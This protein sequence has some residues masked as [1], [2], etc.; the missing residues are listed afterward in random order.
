MSSEPSALRKLGAALLNAT[1]MLAA[2]VLLLA[3]VLVWQV[4]GL[5]SDLREGLRT[6][7]VA[8]QPQMQATREAARAAL[9]ELPATA[10]AREDL[11]ALVDQ[12]EARPTAPQDTESLLRRIAFAV[13]AI[14][15]QGVLEGLMTGESAR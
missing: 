3:V 7:L 14:A 8:L 5:A 15:A 13:I 11:A 2:L 1:L 9:E 4:R 10:P 6:E 12:L